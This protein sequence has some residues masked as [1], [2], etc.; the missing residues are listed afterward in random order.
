M[1]FA[2]PA[3]N[4][5]VKIPGTCAGVPALVKRDVVVTIPCSRQRLFN[6]SDIAVVPRMDDPVAVIRDFMCRA[7]CQVATTPTVSPLTR[8]RARPGERQRGIDSFSL[9]LQQDSPRSK[10][11][12]WTFV[13]TLLTTHGG[14]P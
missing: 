4:M 6:D 10:E 2:A 5:Q 7:P 9:C 14:S 12:G 8:Q 11:A 3:P 1:R 13:A